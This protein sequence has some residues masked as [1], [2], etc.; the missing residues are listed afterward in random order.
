M[1]VNSSSLFA[2]L[3]NWSFEVLYLR[4]H[5]T[6]LLQTPDAASYLL[7]KS[8]ETELIVE[9]GR[10]EH[11]FIDDI[12]YAISRFPDMLHPGLYTFIA[13]FCGSLASASLKK[14]ERNSSSSFMSATSV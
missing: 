12:L 1:D 11:V 4:H 13:F 9:F 2:N 6:L 14:E 7:Q 10:R 3:V 5:L 8:L